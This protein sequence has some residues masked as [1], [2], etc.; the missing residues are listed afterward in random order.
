VTTGRIA[1]AAATVIPG[2]GVPLA[3]G[4][5]VLAEAGIPLPIPADL[6]ML[7]VGERA[8]AGAVP[9]WVAV[10]GLEAAAAVGTTALFVLARGPGYG[11]LSRLGPRV[12]LTAERLGRATALVE[13]RGRPART[14]GRA[15][16]GFRTM[17][18][19]A[20]GGSGVA[21][22]RAL[23]A[24]FVGS[25]LFLQL[26][27]FL[28]FFLGPVARSALDEARGPTLVVIGALLAAAIAFWLVR[29]GR[30]AGAEGW[31]E[32]ACPACLAL[33]A[34]SER[35]QL[36]PVGSGPQPALE[37]GP[38][39]RPGRTAGPEARPGTTEAATG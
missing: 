4:L 37:A 33:D 29:R 31:A 28:G 24:L 3:L 11:L 18:V 6:V 12:G 34:V 23:P 9:L 32:A 17:T 10:V 1:A 21:A 38:A 16:P 2:V 15:V 8:A 39:D 13:R 20:A 25:S 22:R 36:L 35:H 19:L 7:F 14:V 27:L 30:R 5:V 26:H